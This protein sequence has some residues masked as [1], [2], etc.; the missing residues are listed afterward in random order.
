MMCCAAAECCLDKNPGQRPVDLQ[1]A[2]PIGAGS[3]AGLEVM[4][5]N[6]VT[7][8]DGHGP[9]ERT[10]CRRSVRLRAF[11]E[12]SQ[13]R[14][15]DPVDLMSMRGRVAPLGRALMPM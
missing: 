7:P 6:T 13:M 9:G 15:A 10:H 12:F 4:P 1:P 8:G 11:A 14:R 3:K 5:I 2:I